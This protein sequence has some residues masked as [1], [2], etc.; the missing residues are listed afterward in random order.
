MKITKYCIA[1]VGICAIIIWAST[2]SCSNKDLSCSS[3]S[4]FKAVSEILIAKCDKCHKDA[5]TAV[6]YGKGIVINAKDS[7]SL[8]SYINTNGT[9][10]LLL[11]DIEGTGLNLMPLGGPKLTDCEI[12][13][14][15]N[16][17]ANTAK[18]FA[19]PCGDTSFRT[20]S[21]I[22]VNSCGKCHGD[23][24]KAANYGRGLIY[25]FSDWN[26]VTDNNYFNNYDTTTATGSTYDI[27]T[28][29]G[30]TFLDIQGIVN[31]RTHPMPLGGP[32]LSDCEIS[33][34]RTW[35]FKGAPNN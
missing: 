17:I 35:L 13:T 15:R 30:T 1:L 33:T 22:L 2:S 16:W 26:T 20:V 21:K 25:D 8:L 32:K 11:K 27:N 14:I 12:G 34:I 31:S 23:S 9:G 7:V 29:G 3:D 24:T 28:F 4:G 19:T 6:L 10:G 5:A 18:S